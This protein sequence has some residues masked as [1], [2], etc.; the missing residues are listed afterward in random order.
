[1]L[2]FVQDKGG[3]VVLEKSPRILKDEASLIRVIE[4]DISMT[5]VKE[6]T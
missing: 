6:M 4:R 5:A 2:N 3:R 1:V